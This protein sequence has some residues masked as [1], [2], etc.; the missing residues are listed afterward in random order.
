MIN[1]AV[2]KRPAIGKKT[3]HD[4]RDQGQI[5][6]ILY[7]QKKDVVSLSISTKEFLQVLQKHEHLVK[8]TVDG[9]EETVVIKEVQYNTYGDKIL[10]VDFCRID[11]S[12]K[13]KVAVPIQFVGT[14]K[15]LQKG[16]VWEKALRQLEISCLPINIPESI[17][18][19]V[20]DLDLGTVLRVKD[21]QLDPLFTM[22]TGKEVVACTVQ[23]PK[24]QAE[25]PATDAA[26][27]EKA[28]PEIIKKAKPQE[29][30]EEK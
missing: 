27:E 10:H 3:C 29:A 15:G 2:S 13:L 16:G 4:L 5:P 6:A 14:P 11:I 28:E 21:I 25:T 22:E 18:I 24:V 19:N 30:E 7:G 23:L 1:I 20:D 8:F 26:I 12:K 17:K 9:K